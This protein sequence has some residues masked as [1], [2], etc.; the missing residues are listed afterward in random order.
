MGV[1][2]QFVGVAEWRV[3]QEGP[4][5]LVIFIIQA[6]ATFFCLGVGRLWWCHTRFGWGIVR[7]QQQKHSSEVHS[8]DIPY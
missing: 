4:G 3:R 1:W 7:A 2:V 6:F 8:R 5:A